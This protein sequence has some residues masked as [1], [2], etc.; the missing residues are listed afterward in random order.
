MVEQP[1]LQTFEGLNSGEGTSHGITHKKGPI[2]Q[3]W[4]LTMRMLV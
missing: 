2:E 3:F 4:F 1:D